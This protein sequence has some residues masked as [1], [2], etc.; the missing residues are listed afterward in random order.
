MIGRSFVGGCF[1]PIVETKTV[2]GECLDDRH[3]VNLPNTM[4][5][6]D[7][8]VSSKRR[9]KCRPGALALARDPQTGLVPGCTTVDTRRLNSTVEVCM[10]KFSLTVRKVIVSNILFSHRIMVSF[11]PL[12]TQPHFFFKSICKPVL[13]RLE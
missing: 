5:E 3:C 9:C 8:L 11:D 7:P 4:C 2:N 13:S 6:G 1:D 12:P 10:K